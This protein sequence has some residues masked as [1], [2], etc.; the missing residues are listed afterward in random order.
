MPPFSPAVPPV[1][2]AVHH[3]E[4]P[5]RDLAAAIA[6][7]TDV[8]GFRLDF[9]WGEPA[10][11]AGVSLDRAS[12][13]LNQQAG[14]PPP[15]TVFFFVDDVD[16]LHALH[17]A[18]GAA[19][20]CA[21]E[22]RVYHVRDYSLRTP[23]GHRLVFGQG[24][25]PKVPA[26]PIERVDVPV[27]LE[28]RLAAVLADLAARKRMTIS[29]CLEETLL[30]T[31]EPFGDGVA[32]PHTRADLRAIAELKARHG[33]DYDCHASYRFVERVADTA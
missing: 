32:S 18:R 19:L 33:L 12:V 8:L 6:H 25:M 11:F 3:P 9:T 30:H 20:E 13:F 16:A 14:D 22:D 7:C 1:G 31:F 5:V 2:C 26:L 29:E 24:L 23:D 4:L 15:A 28:R 17:A 10:T 21:P 27:R